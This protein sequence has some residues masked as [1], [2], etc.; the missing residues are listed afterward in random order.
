[1]TV[2]YYLRKQVKGTN[3][4]KKTCQLMVLIVCVTLDCSSASF[5][6]KN[7]QWM[8]TV[9]WIHSPVIVISMEKKFPSLYA[10]ICIYKRIC[11]H[12]FSFL[13][14]SI[15]LFQWSAVLTSG[16]CPRLESGLSDF[17]LTPSR[18][19]FHFLEHLILMPKWQIDTWILVWYGLW[20][21]IINTKTIVSKR[22]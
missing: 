11:S 20:G 5:V 7:I 4:W 16:H 22:K 1:M 18:E 9:L 21:L 14:T 10:C 17:W 8:S 12:F 2:P 19:M 15:I 13:L 3:G 6:Y